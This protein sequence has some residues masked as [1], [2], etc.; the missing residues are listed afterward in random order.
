MQ[1]RRINT[2]TRI[3]KTKRSPI[4]EITI[5]TFNT[6]FSEYPASES[7]A[8]ES[9][10]SEPLNSVPDGSVGSISLADSSN[11]STAVDAPELDVLWKVP[12]SSSSSVEILSIAPAMPDADVPRESGRPNELKECNELKEGNDLNDC[13]DLKEYKSNELTKYIILPNLN[14]ISYY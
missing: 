2:R 7:P 8:S 14:S 13:N 9:P 11:R 6:Q 1:K 12:S 10:A 5:L 3:D 4:N